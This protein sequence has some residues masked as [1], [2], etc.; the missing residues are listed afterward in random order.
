MRES[1][2]YLRTIPVKFACQI[3]FSF[4]IILGFL[5]FIES[6]AAAYTPLHDSLEFYVLILA[7]LPSIAGLMAMLE[8]YFSMRLGETR[9]IRHLTKLG[10]T[11]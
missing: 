2:K 8:Y 1:R 7:I 3:S 4:L 5:R 9:L 10:V 6:R 11:A